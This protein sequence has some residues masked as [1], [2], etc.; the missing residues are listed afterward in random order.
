MVTGGGV[1]RELTGLGHEAYLAALPTSATDTDEISSPSGYAQVGVRAGNAVLYVNYREEFAFLDRAG[2]VAQILAREAARHAG[3]TGG[4][5]EDRGTFST[6]KEGGKS[7]PISDRSLADLPPPA[8]TPAKDN[9]FAYCSRRPAQSVYGATWASDERSYLWNLWRFPLVFRAPKHL[10]RERKAVD[11]PITYTCKSRPENV[12]AGFLPD[13]RL[14]LRH[15][16]QR[17]GDGCVSTRH[18]RPC[19]GLVDEGRRLHVLR[20]G[21]VRRAGP[22]PHGDEASL[23]PAGQ[24]R[25][26]PARLP[27]LGQGR[28]CPGSR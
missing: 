1:F 21:S 14:E 28:H 20:D 19:A 26:C 25:T 3:L 8:K 27:V 7:T 9:R 16:L 15:L 5:V 24:E 22:L 11:D 2:E 13:L 6:G 4:D 10:D 23:G 12:K 18:S 17:P